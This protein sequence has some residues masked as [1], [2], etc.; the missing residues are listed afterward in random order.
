VSQKN[1]LGVCMIISSFSPIVG[2]SE[3]QAQQLSAR[4]I[5]RGLQV[6]VLTRRYQGL[7]RY[8]EIDGVPVYRV[9][10]FGP[11]PVAAMLFTLASLVWL[12]LNRHR[13]QIVH[14]H[15]VLSPAIIGALAKTF[16][17]KNLV[18][19]V[20]GTGQ[21]GGIAQINAMPLSSL[22]RKL[23]RQVDRF[24]YLNDVVYG[25]LQS[26]GFAD[27]AIKLPNGVNTD[28]FRPVT[29]EVK[30][31]LRENLGLPTTCGLVIFTGRL[32]SLKRLDILLRSWADILQSPE[33]PACHL[34]VLGEGEESPSLKALA[35]QLH[36]EKHLSFLG[37]K[38]NV[39]GYLQASDI[40]VLPSETEGISNSLLEAMA[41]GLAVIATNVGGTGEILKHQRDGFLVQP[42]SQS[43]LADG[44]LQ[45]L[46]DQALAQRLGAEARKTVEAGYS[47][48]YVVEQYV[49]LYASLLSQS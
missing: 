13:Y 49:G 33:S 45:L 30:P 25:E 7:D 9:P 46:Q 24:I 21:A 15:Q 4:L 40:F 1:K 41:C 11:R 10:A 27:V 5:A 12:F 18:V 16:W 29:E 44:L 47:L 19:K 36:I 3:R 6:C 20:T 35:R 34:L 48:D 38:E 2:G 39:S 17:K 37:R 8:D 26:F 22:R 32:N 28:K 43:Q 42:R 23:L 14:C 31:T